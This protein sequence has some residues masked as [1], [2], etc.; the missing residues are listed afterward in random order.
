VLANGQ[1]NH[2]LQEGLLLLDGLSRYDA[3]AAMSVAANYLPASHAMAP[4]TSTD[5]FYENR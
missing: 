5:L 1:S 3:F 2:P 4:P